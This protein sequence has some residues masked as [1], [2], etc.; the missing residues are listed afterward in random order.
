MQYIGFKQ[1]SNI[2]TT[3]FLKKNWVLDKLGLSDFKTRPDPDNKFTY[4]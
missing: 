2:W 3:W 4:L 1:N